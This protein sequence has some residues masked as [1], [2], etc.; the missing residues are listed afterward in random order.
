MRQLTDPSS[1]V[2]R[3]SGR[4]PDFFI[5]GH[6]KC[7]TTALYMMLRQHPQ[8]FLPDLKEPE[9]LATD[10]SRRFQSPMS[11]PLPET[12]NQYLSLFV[13]ARPDQLAG[14]ASA[15]YLSSTVAA[16]QIASINDKAQAIAI[17]REPASF[18]RSLHF[19]HLQD[20]IEVERDLRRALALE[21]QRRNGQHIPRRSYRPQVLLYSEHVRYTEQLR[22]YHEALGLK[23]V[24]V[25]IYEE[26]RVDNAAVVRQV[27]SHL[28][29][30]DSV[31][32]AP[33]QANPTV[34]VRSQILDDA[35]HRFSV[36]RG[37]VSRSV[38]A[39]IKAVL[40]R[41]VRRPL[42][43][44]AQ[45]QLVYATPPPPDDELMANLRTRF[46]PEVERLSDYLGRDLV[47]LWGYGRV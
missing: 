25:L 18:L 21:D 16:S 17:F 8:L 35:L 4:V 31:S 37:P 36:G 30:D 10:M 14:E 6:A 15:F 39:G 23:Q 11:G 13:E 40:P 33:E 3:P 41:S 9:F 42:L 43:N 32:L 7:G 20:H 38:K 2:Q 27:L 47:D 24:L 44:K 12:L 26:F 1:D 46:K 5:V 34:A 28:G 45:S 19:Q 29:V 22:R